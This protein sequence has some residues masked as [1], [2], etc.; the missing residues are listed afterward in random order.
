MSFFSKILQFFTN[1]FKP[2]AAE[3]RAAPIEAPQKS[4]GGPLF[5]V[6]VSHYQGKIDWAQK[7]K[8]GVMFAFL[9]A[10]EGNTVSDSM[11]KQNY[12]GCKKAGIL[13]GAYHFFRANDDPDRQFQNFK[14]RIGKVAPGDLPPVLD[15][16]TKDGMRPSVIK[17]RVL[18]F[19]ELCRAEWGIDPIL[20]ASPSYLESLGDLTGFDKYPLWI[21]HYGVSHPRVPSPWVTW[22]FWQYTDAD[23]HDLDRFNGG[24]GQLVRFRRAG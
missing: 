4:S 5:G 16:E 18:R 3:I 21:A 2:K 17:R 8:D 24:A 19:L 20:Y 10:S 6:D 13:V 12:D 7:A 22:T 11:Y 15:L 23:G 1:L 9:K 14:S